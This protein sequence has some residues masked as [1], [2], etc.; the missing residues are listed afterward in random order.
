MCQLEEY[1]GMPREHELSGGMR[2]PLLAIYFRSVKCKNKFY[3]HKGHSALDQC[4][5]TF[6]AL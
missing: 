3:V 2:K 4:E 1:G 5:S 6:Q